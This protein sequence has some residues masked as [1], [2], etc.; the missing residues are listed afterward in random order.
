M[1]AETKGSICPYF[2]PIPYQAAVSPSVLTPGKQVAGPVNFK[3]F[4]CQ[5]ENC[6]IFD[7]CQGESSPT[8]LEEQH[9][10]M[11]EAFLFWLEDTVP[12]TYSTAIKSLRDKLFPPLGADS[13][14]VLN[15]PQE[16]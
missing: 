15:G 5:G 16:K 10:G 2:P 8:A 9:C 11:F 6:A 1:P 4:P 3:F 12:A 14:P 13:G 7:R